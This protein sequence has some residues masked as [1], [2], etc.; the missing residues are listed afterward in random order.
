[1]RRRARPCS[2]AP[3]RTIS[4]TLAFD[5]DV[6]APFGAMLPL[7]VVGWSEDDGDDA[8]TERGLRKPTLSELRQLLFNFVPR[9]AHTRSQSTRPVG[10]TP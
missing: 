3:Q 4:K 7:S 2:A 8:T 5:F 1:M 6:V 10:T 9:C